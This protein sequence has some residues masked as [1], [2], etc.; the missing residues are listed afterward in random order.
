[1][2]KARTILRAATQG[3]VWVGSIVGTSK[4]LKEPRNKGLIT[5]HI[6]KYKEQNLLTLRRLHQG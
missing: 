4:L 3:P 2:S 5:E 1:M 6:C